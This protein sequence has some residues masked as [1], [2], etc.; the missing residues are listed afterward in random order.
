M[1]RR[2]MVVVFGLLVALLLATAVGAI[3]TLQGILADLRHLDSEAWLVNE[4]ANDLGTSIS[5]LEIELYELEVGRKRR[6]DRLI[7]LMEA[8]G[9]QVEAVTG[10]YVSH[11][12]ENGPI[13]RRIQA[14]LPD[15][16]EHVASLGTASDPQW[17]NLHRGEALAM[18]A[19]LRADI[20]QLGGQVRAHGQQEQAELTSRFRWMVL[21]LTL[22][23]LVVI[24][25]AIVVLLRMSTMVL[26]PVE[27]LLEATR[28]LGQERF[29]YRVELD[30]KDEFDE[31]ARAYNSL[32]GQLQANEQ[33]KLET[34]AQVAATLNHELNNA[35]A[36]IELQLQL[37]SRQAGGNARVEKCAR[38]IHD[39][40][41]RMT[42]TVELLKRV[43]RIVLTDY[44]SG[45]KMLD[46]EKSAQEDP[47][48]A[49]EEPHEAGGRV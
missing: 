47:E 18:I 49:E 39:S 20:L 40:L 44:V 46:L 14:S 23:F 17:A 1:L 48:P 15:F 22:V 26:R 29:E 37:L 24:N 8:M 33:R 30:Q 45:V 3:W 10:S 28:Q 31:L 42:R 19:Q 36:I 21:A 27:K 4:Q 32:A 9:R 11:L 35:V 2:K 12:P 43:R 38:Q 5:L 16:A 7:D 6:L 25:V 41:A 13:L 34:L